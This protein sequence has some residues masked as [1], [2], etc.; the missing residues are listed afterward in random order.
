LISVARL[1]FWPASFVCSFRFAL[2]LGRLVLAG[3][4]GSC[5]SLLQIA[6][7]LFA[8]R[9]LCPLPAPFR[10]GSATLR[11]PDIVVL[12]DPGVGGLLLWDHAATV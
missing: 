8:T 9:L 5:A 11:H 3:L 12:P 2:P 6:V 4:F 7:L 1:S 10:T